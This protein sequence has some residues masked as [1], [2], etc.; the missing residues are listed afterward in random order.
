MV[1][2]AHDP[3]VDD[4]ALMRALDSGAFFIGALGSRK[5]QALR[6]KRLGQAGYDEAALARIHGPVG[7]DIG[8]L[9]PAEI[10]I[11]ILAELTRARR[12]GPT[13]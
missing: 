4:V 3:K 9:S 1:T 6:L 11:S 2:L 12:R 10:A 5:N 8:A 13:S 7:L